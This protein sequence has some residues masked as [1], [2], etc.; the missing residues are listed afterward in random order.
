MEV[1]G[2][3]RRGSKYAYDGSDHSRRGSND[4]REVERYPRG[5]HDS[6]RGRRSRSHSYRA[7]R[8]SMENHG[9][10]DRYHMDGRGRRDRSSGSNHPS[11]DSYAKRSEDNSTDEARWRARR[12]ER[13]LR[14][15][16]DERLERGHRDERDY[17][18][19]SDSRDRRDRRERR[20]HRDRRGRRDRDERKRKYSRLNPNL[21][22]S[23]ER[24][25][26]RER[27]RRKLQAEC[28]KKAGGF[29]KLADME[30]HETTS[31]F[32][33]GFQWVAKTNQSSTSHLDPAVMNSTRKLRRLYFGNLPLHLGLSENEFQ[34]TVWDEM[35]KRKFCNDEKINPVLYVWFAKDKGNYGF[36]E[37]STVE[38]TERALT[39]DGML[40]R[41]VALKV[42][43]PNDYSTNVMK[44]NQPSIL[45]NVAGVS[46]V[47]GVASGVTSGVGNLYGKPP[48]PPGGTPPSVLRE[49]HDPGLDNQSNLQTKYL[50]VLE[51]VSEESVNSEDYSS[52]LED[53]KD[54]FHSQGIIINAI[55]IT[56]KYAQMTPFSVGD[57]VIEFEN[58]ASVDSSIVNMS[59]RKYEGRVIRMTKVDQ[60]TYDV[61][62]RPIIRD[63]Y[64]QNGI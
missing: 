2:S 28:I 17:R 22:S 38:E 26:S 58:A 4:D 21:S 47:G 61:H 36:V 14:D 48:P 29:K 63:L 49:A 43:R 1:E 23:H 35:K 32:W 64:E 37:F 25:R 59:N 7:R 12:G 10:G 53:I 19:R 57:V 33:D 15:V 41:G 30:G 27:R 8:N 13:D 24:S 56:P 46:G 50:R 45:Q 39:M 60:A 51:I 40:C 31:V 55:L 42:S 11:R 52:I 20:E 6:P 5:K 44:S 18:D 16:R 3:R 34:E 54:G 62:V 9:G